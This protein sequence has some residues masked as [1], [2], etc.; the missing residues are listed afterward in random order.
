MVYQDITQQR[1]AVNLSV[2]ENSAGNPSEFGKELPL[3]TKHSVSALQKAARACA[4][5]R[6][7]WHSTCITFPCPWSLKTPT[8]Q[9]RKQQS[10]W[11]S[12]VAGA[13]FSSPFLEEVL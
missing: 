9:R 8:Y 10:N 5:R 3:A 12:V 6:A 11:P 13:A 1:P 7:T 2:S 4:L